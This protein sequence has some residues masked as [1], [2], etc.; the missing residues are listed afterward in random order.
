MAW[1]MSSKDSPWKTFFAKRLSAEDA[2]FERL[3]QRDF[4]SCKL[5]LEMFFFLLSEPKDVLTSLAARCFFSRAWFWR[6]CVSRHRKFITWDTCFHCELKES[7]PPNF[8]RLPS[9]FKIPRFGHSISTLRTEDRD[10]SFKILRPNSLIRDLGNPRA[11]NDIGLHVFLKV[12]P[13]LPPLS[14]HQGVLGGISK[15]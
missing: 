11:P 4:F 3:S 6:S 5:T 2:F 7:L 14:T 13:P 9:Y 15:K 8:I 10:A 1:E 12:S